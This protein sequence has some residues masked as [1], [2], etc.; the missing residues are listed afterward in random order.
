M[1]LRMRVLEADRKKVRNPTRT[2]NSSS[3][4]EP[5]S[6]TPKTVR[7]NMPASLDTARLARLLAA[8]ALRKPEQL[9]SAEETIAFLRELAEKR[10]TRRVALL[11]GCGVNVVNASDTDKFASTA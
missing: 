4:M 10:E 7:L 3:F 2:F 5:D 11:A 1:R 8:K 6:K 9:A